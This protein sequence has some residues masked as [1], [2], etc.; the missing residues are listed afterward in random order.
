MAE[1]RLVNRILYIATSCI[2]L[3]LAP[4]SVSECFYTCS[5]IANQFSSFQ[6]D[7]EYTA[8][9]TLFYVLDVATCFG[10][11]Y[12]NM[13]ARNDHLSTCQRCWMR[14]DEEIAVRD[15]SPGSL[16]AVLRT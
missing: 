2:S 15:L 14:E 9:S 16:A 8:S 1:R 12:F 4:E 11:V 10:H 13:S 7:R 5:L 3:S 6:H